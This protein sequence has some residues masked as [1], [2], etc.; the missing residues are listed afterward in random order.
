[1]SLPLQSLLRPYAELDFT[2][3]ALD[4]RVSFTRASQKTYFGA[5]GLMHTAAN[6]ECPLEF[7][8]VTGLV[9]GRSFWPQAT[10]SILRSQ[11]F[12][13]AAWVTTATRTANALVAPDG[14]MTA[15]MLTSTTAGQNTQAVVAT[16]TSHVFSV[17]LHV[18][19]AALP[20]TQ[21]ILRNTT[22]ATN[23]CIATVTFATMTVTGAG[24]SIQNVGGGWYRVSASSSTGITVG[25]TLTCYAGTF[26]GAGLTFY[27]WGAQF[28]P[29]TVASPYIATTTAAVTR[30]QEVATAP[31]SA[32]KFNL[33]GCTTVAEFMVPWTTTSG[34]GVLSLDVSGRLIYSAGSLVFG[35]YDGTN[36]ASASAMTAGVFSKIASTFGSGGLSISRAG[37]A[38][39]TAPYDGQMGAGGN[40][41]LRIG[42]RDTGG[43]GIMSGTIKRVR[44]Y[45]T[46][47]YGAAQQALAA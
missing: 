20:T 46:P 29:G 11:E 12:D 13:N 6:D 26:S 4:S 14:T 45:P 25:N 28:E 1:M 35:V 37:A 16:S 44:V 9:L 31:L 47:H 2:R 42:H 32:V 23:L 27:V 30:A 10:N 36:V 39:V 41:L 5:D 21:I 38:P 18:G 8:P 3:F 22:T 17:F 40:T 24:A 33:S 7:D 34:I 43:A 19:N 15:D